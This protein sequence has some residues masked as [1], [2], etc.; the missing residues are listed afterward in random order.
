MRFHFVCLFVLLIA[1]S[2][3]MEQSEMNASALESTGEA[4]L[5][6]HINVSLPEVAQTHEQPPKEIPLPCEPIEIPIQPVLKPE[7]EGSYWL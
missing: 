3:A 6:L 1:L 2:R 7:A 5:S 4:T